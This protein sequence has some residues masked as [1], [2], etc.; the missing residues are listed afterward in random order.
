MKCTIDRVGSIRIVHVFDPVNEQMLEALFHTLCDVARECDGR[1]VISL[2]ESPRIDRSAT[3]SLAERAR[4]FGS[5]VT[6]VVPEALCGA[7]L[8]SCFGEVFGEQARLRALIY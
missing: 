4:T 1:V 3:N 7:G 8:A 2:L 6:L 5:R